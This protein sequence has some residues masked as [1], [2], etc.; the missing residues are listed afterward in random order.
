M[1]RKSL[2]S[3]LRY[4][5][6]SNAVKL[7][8]SVLLVLVVPKALG[9]AEYGYFQL[10]LFLGNYL[11]LLH[12][13][14][15]DG[16][17]LRHGGQRYSSLPKGL[18]TAQF[19]ALACLQVFFSGL[20]ALAAVRMEAVAPR[21]VLLCLC[22]STPLTILRSFLQA[23]VQ[24]TFRMQL[25]ATTLFVENIFF[26]ALL[27]GMVLPGF[28]SLT[29]LMVLDIA[30][31]VFALIILL[32]NCRDLISAP[33]LRRGRR[34][35]PLLG[36]IRANIS[37]GVFVVASFLASAL[38]VGIVRMGVALIWGV[39]GFGEL[40]L[41]LN[42]A[43]FVVALLTAAGVTLFP[44]LRRASRTGL[45]SGY[46][47]MRTSL[48]MILVLCLFVGW[49]MAYALTVWLPQYQL[50]AHYLPLL[51][52]V[53]V[54]D[55]LNVL[56]LTPY[57]KALRM[58]RA[59]LYNNVLVVGLSFV[60]TVIFAYC[61]RSVVASVA[62][63]PLLAF[64]RCLVAD[65]LVSRRLGTRAGP[66]LP[67]A[68]LMAAVFTLSGWFLDGGIGVLIFACAVVIVLV[69]RRSV[70]RH[71]IRYVYDRLMGPIAS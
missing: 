7:L 10:Y 15:V 24:A 16:I 1:G 68:G 55:G 21:D 30:R 64:L 67:L 48:G 31:I 12:F 52:P 53:M 65:R 18:I 25:Y 39:E 2:L 26:G 42:L 44:L 47:A 66:D 6:S 33:S 19:W 40:S 28:A 54:F 11:S 5:I 60:S 13:G 32:Y 56:L 63:I 58:E 69:V 29:G 36:E 22:I 8:V 57:L 38:V 27:V 3:T 23:V 50:S 9:V 35:R 49:P 34:F 14:W 62:V 61:M 71:A 43:N 51:L 70:L 46:R 4:V 37:A 20:I 45:S 41:A 59:M 17:A